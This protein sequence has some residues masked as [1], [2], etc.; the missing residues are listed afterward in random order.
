MFVEICKTKGDHPAEAGFT[1]G[2]CLDLLHCSLALRAEEFH[3]LFMGFHMVLNF[4]PF[5][6]RN[7][8]HL[9]FFLLHFSV[10]YANGYS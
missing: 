10:R 8:W 6:N 2:G 3:K 4:N 7:T 1:Y 9:L 5:Y